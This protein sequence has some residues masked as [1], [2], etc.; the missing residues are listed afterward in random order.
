M[1]VKWFHAML[2]VLL[3]IDCAVL[4]EEIEEVEEASVIL[5]LILM[6]CTTVNHYFLLII[7]TVKSGKIAPPTLKQLSVNIKKMLHICKK[8]ILSFQ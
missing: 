4:V 6:N 1:V 2:L 7:N 3:W 5:V 8:G